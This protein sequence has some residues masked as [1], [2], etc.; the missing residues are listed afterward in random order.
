MPGSA[1]SAMR[2]M[3]DGLRA[4]DDERA[5]KTGTQ[6]RG[7]SEEEEEEECGE[8]ESE[9]RYTHGA[10]RGL[11]QAHPFLNNANADATIMVR[12]EE[13][14]HSHFL[15]DEPLAGESDD[16]DSVQLQP[17]PSTQTRVPQPR[18][19]L[20]R[21]IVVNMNSSKY[22]V[23]AQAARKMG[24]RVARNLGP[25]TEECNLLWVDSYITFETFSSLNKYQKANHFPGMSELAKCA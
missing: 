22:P 16:D 17:E 6:G 23:I 7:D 8:E 21:R 13:M 19:G 9:S 15:V 24:W 20:K 10:L 11:P 1:P 5:E 25:D 14:R 12:S 2:R 4:A 3:G 18:R